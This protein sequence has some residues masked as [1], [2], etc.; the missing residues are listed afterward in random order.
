MLKMPSARGSG[1]K[2]LNARLSVTF[3]MLNFAGVTFC[4][5]FW[6]DCWRVA[7]QQHEPKKPEQSPQGQRSVYQCPY[8]N[9]RCGEGA[10]YCARCNLDYQK[11]LAMLGNEYW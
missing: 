6:L 8:R 11:F 9:K 10:I 7:E 1:R 2:R 3:V 4:S 5:S